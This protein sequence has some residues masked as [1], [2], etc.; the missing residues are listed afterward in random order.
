M[1]FTLSSFHALNCMDPSDDKNTKKEVSLRRPKKRLSGHS[2]E[3]LQ[4]KSP[5]PFR[6]SV[7]M[8]DLLEQKEIQSQN[9]F[10]NA[11]DNKNDS[12]IEFYLKDPYFNPNVQDCI[13]LDTAF[14]YAAAQRNTPLIKTLLQD[15]RI[16]ASI[17]NRKKQTAR[18]AFISHDLMNPTEEELHV[19]TI[20]FARITLD[21]IIEQQ[22]QRLK[23][24]YFSHSMSPETL[25]AMVEIIKKK[26]LLFQTKQHGD[27]AIPES[28]LLPAYA[29]NDFIRNTIRFRIAQQ[30]LR[31]TNK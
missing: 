7:S 6:K 19:R 24:I 10:I 5:A 29:T 27:Q 1:V 23:D 26:F 3:K 2:A 11:V 28:A 31:N 18:D 8:S 16:D 21:T 15:H 4:K 20:I 25:D 30:A 13:T 14:H 9:P 12:M 22:A 17:R